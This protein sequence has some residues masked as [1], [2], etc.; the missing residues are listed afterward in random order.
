MGEYYDWVNVDRREYI[1][2]A[3][4][5]LGNKKHESMQ[6]G[7]TLLLALREL[8]SEEWAGNH[9]LFMGDEI[10]VPA[11]TD[12]ETLRILYE[13]TVQAGCPENASGTVIETYKNI[14]GLFKAAEAEV[15][16]EIQYFLDDVNNDLPMRL[17]VY[18]VD[19]SYPYKGLFLRTGR[20][21]RY[22]INHTKRICYSFEDTI[23]LNLDH[24]ENAFAD[25][26]PVLMGYG[27][28]SETGVWA[29]D[30]IGV[31]DEMPDGY[32]LLKEICLD[33]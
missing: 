28:A 8:L 30:V 15:R 3:D 4:F 22:T 21:Y 19:L 16:Q 17:N 9:V 20:D 33:W 7:N 5:D 31:G 13:H 29:G 27:R 23:I 26:L 18:G 6:R 12:N 11:D 2:P 32:E 10:S 24:T 25:P 1:S 14:S